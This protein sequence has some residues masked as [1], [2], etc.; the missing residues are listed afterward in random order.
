[1][2]SGKVPR[3]RMWSEVVKPTAWDAINNGSAKPADVFPKVDEKLNALLN[4]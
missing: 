2:V 1:V 4:E 3:S